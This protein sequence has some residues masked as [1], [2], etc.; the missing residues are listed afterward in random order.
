MT[1]SVE[2][3]SRG[4]TTVGRVF[5]EN[6]Q[7]KKLGNELKIPGKRNPRRC[8]QSSRQTIRTSRP[9]SKQNGGVNLPKESSNES[10]NLELDPQIKAE[11]TK[12]WDLEDGEMT[13]EQILM[14]IR[15]GHL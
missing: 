6:Q 4:L 5:T 2:E 11:F 8:S 12:A 13:D 3:E 10:E 7:G 14:A 9:W 1:P 15:L